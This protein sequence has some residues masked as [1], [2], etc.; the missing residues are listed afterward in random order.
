MGALM[1][2]GYSFAEIKGALA[3]VTKRGKEDE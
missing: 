3:I 2:Y 1:R